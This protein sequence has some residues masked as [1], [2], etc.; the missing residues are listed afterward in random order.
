VALEL[1]FGGELQLPVDVIRDLVNDSFAIQ[2]G[3][4]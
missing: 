4:P 1:L 2:F 3:A